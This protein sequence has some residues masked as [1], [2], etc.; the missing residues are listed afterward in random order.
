MWII[1]LDAATRIKF[2]KET[3][4]LHKDLSRSFALNTNMPHVWATF[5]RTMSRA[6]AIYMS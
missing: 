5:S 6:S 3:S 1:R 2:W 4:V